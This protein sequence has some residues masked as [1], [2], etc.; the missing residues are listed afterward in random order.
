MR[1][2]PRNRQNL[3]D[4]AI[5]CACLVILIGCGQPAGNPTAVAAPADTPPPDNQKTPVSSNA[6]DKDDSPAKAA[7]AT[8]DDSPFRRRIPAPALDGGVSWLN[9]AG[10]VDIKDLRGKWVV[11][12]FWTY[13]CIN[14][15]HILPELKKLEHAHPD[16][17]VVIGVHSAKFEA[18]QD[19]KNIL[20]AVLR[21]E[22][23]HPVV[24]D[25]NHKI[26]D[27][28]MVNAWPSIR[29]IDPEGYL[30]AGH[31]AEF[32][33][34]LLD[35]F[36]KE[37]SPYYDKKGALNRK[38]I[39]FD[40][41]AAQAKKTPL[42]FPGKVLAD[43]KS[44]RLFIA[45]SNHN[46]IVIAGLDGQLQATIGSGAAGAKDGDYK[47]ATFD[48][49][50]GMALRDDTLYVAD[51]ENHLLRKV[52]LKTQQVVTIAGIGSQ[53]RGLWPGID[54]GALRRGD[55]VKVPERFYGPPKKTALNSPWDLWIHNNDLFIAMAGPHQIWRMPLDEKEIGVYA[56][57]GREDIVDGPLCPNE[58]HERGYCSFAQPSG[59]S[60]DKDYLYVADS[61]GSSIRAV[62]FDTDKEVKT[63]VGT[64]SL[65]FGRLFQFGDK[66]GKGDSVRLQH[67]L[68][69][70]AVA[71]T[72]YI[73]DT[74][75]SKIKALDPKS[76]EVKTIA[77][78]GKD[79][80][81]QLNEP[82]GISHALGKLY[83]ADTNN[84]RI[85]TVDL[86]NGNRV[87]P[88][89]IAG[90]TAPAPAAPMPVVSEEKP[91][92]PRAVE[93]AVPAATVK[94]VDGKITLH[95][96]VKLP[97]GFKINP[98]APMKYLVEAE[99]DGT[100]DRQA[101][102]KGEK[103]DPP[104]AEFDIRLPIKGTAG[105]DK[106]RVSIGLN[107]CQSG[108]GGLC[109]LGSVVFVVPLKISPDAKE[110]TVTLPYDAP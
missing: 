47:T 17:L 57:N 107:Y 49:P 79:D 44:A 7:D 11:L 104:A 77:G 64:A 18:E 109:K 76:T 4:L 41:A 85:V 92:F 38:P 84:H 30:V 16:D 52:D 81:S 32:G 59:L 34:E 50:Q 74:Y 27:A 63:V 67:C 35:T 13:C 19:S 90:L 100:V 93:V 33:W 87:A 25:A 60:A 56:G 82:A 3:R 96:D 37:K 73:A 45:D 31:S 78:S 53:G 39:K 40:Q 36:I 70:A 9:S 55:D 61:E 46:R 69:V 99:G 88:L 20:E 97:L 8:S 6:K 22:I 43:E 48:H 28:Y 83:V 91:S 66:D 95:V 102:N 103:L 1:F 42:R 105:S 5:F 62:P 23:E 98:L 14:C 58:P 75:N 108:D 21:Y 12:D 29:I 71:G 51:T 2:M 101:I 80:L 72:L 86:K 110:A 89:E 65:D 26:W 54:L 10:P 68:G 106:L 94:A 24:N 15:M